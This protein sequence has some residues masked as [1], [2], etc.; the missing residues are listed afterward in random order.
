MAM[1]VDTDEGKAIADALVILNGYCLHRMSAEGIGKFRY[2][3]ADPQYSG[4]EKRTPE[5][6]IRRSAM[7]LLERFRKAADFPYGHMY[8]MN[9]STT[10]AKKARGSY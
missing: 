9:G 8:E 6:F 2:V 5:D 3:P 10:H 1:F 7:H 4:Q